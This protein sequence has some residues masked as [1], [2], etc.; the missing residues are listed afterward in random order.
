M[1]GDSTPDDGTND[2]GDFDSST[3]PDTQA[4]VD[5][6]VDTG[7]G[8][9]MDSGVDS[10]KDT[11]TTV[12]DAGNDTTTNLPACAAAYSQGDC[13]SYLAGTSE[14]SSNSHNWLCMTNCENCGTTSDCAPGHANCPWGSVWSD[15]GA[16]H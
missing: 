7:T 12:H 1:S 2:A 8:P 5:S 13:T 16:C 3:G 14:V 9:G 11:G 4:G 15:K 6:A 10:G